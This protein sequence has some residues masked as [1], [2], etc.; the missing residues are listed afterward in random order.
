M[1]SGTLGATVRAVLL[2]VV[3]GAVVAGA[4]LWQVLSTEFAVSTIESA[5]LVSPV[6]AIGVACAYFAA[7]G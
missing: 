4:K 3:V 2:F 5:I 6:A 1:Q 7:S